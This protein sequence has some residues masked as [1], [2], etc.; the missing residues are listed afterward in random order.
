MRGYKIKPG[1]YYLANLRSD[2]DPVRVQVKEELP[3]KEG[4]HHR[5]LVATPNGNTV[6][7]TSNRIL[8]EVPHPQRPTT[9]VEDRV[10]AVQMPKEVLD[11]IDMARAVKQAE[12]PESPAPS[13]APT[14]EPVRPVERTA[15]ASNGT[16]KDMVNVSIALEGTPLV[17]VVVAL[18]MLREVGLNPRLVYVVIHD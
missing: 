5:Y 10:K 14:P 7:A 18:D 16:E 15:G 12:S 4:Q 2:L 17:D 1:K 11:F 8:T 13:P 6:K 3:R 9:P